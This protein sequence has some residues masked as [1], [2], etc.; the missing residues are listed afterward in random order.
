MIHKV[1]IPCVIA[2]ASV[3]CATMGRPIDT[4]KVDAFKVGITTKA[5]VL[6]ALG[7]P[8]SSTVS[9]AGT[10]VLMWTYAHAVAYGGATSTV[11]SCTFGSDGIL[12]NKTVSGSK[13]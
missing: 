3:G 6:E 12:T 1:S 9:S 10:T 2:L 7:E 11:V 5:Q 8:T 4:A 13:M